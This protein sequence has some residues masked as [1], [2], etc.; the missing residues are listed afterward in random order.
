MNFFANRCQR[1]IYRKQVNSLLGIF[2]PI[3]NLTNRIINKIKAIS[4]L[5]LL[6]MREQK[7]QQISSVLKAQN[8]QPA[9]HRFMNQTQHHH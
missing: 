7:P 5:S 1:R 6:K 2:N 4:K 8:K 9:H 3:V